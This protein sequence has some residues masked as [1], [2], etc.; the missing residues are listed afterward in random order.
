M[1]L[2]ICLL[3]LEDANKRCN[4]TSDLTSAGT[5]LVFLLYERDHWVL[6]SLA[7]WCMHNIGGWRSIAINLVQLQ[8]TKVATWAMRATAQASLPSCKNNR[9]SSSNAVCKNHAYAMYKQLLGRMARPMWSCDKVYR[10]ALL[11]QGQKEEVDQWTDNTTTFAS[12]V[13]LRSLL[14]SKA[15]AKM[16]EH[17]GMVQ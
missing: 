1:I 8:L 3:K 10:E 2:I 9:A 5:P 6:Q 17:G 16:Q 13:R 12:K 7:A 4:N 14:Q 15:T 11:T